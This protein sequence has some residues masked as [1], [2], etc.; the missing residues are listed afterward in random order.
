[1]VYYRPLVYKLSN[2]SPFMVDDETFQR[3]AADAVVLAD[4]D[5]AKLPRA[6]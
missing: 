2:L 3:S 1:M 5:R 4:A 6:D